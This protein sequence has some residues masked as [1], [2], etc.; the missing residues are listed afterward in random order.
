[1]KRWLLLSMLAHAGFFGFATLAA[2][3]LRPQFMFPVMS[4]R[5]VSVPPVAERRAPEP[6]EKKRE[7]EPRKETKKPEKAPPKSKIDPLEAKK[8][9]PPKAEVQPE[10]RPE[11]RAAPMVPQMPNAVP[12]PSVQ[13]AVRDPN[14]KF[15][16]YYMLLQRKLDQS[17]NPPPLQYGNPVIEVVILF[18]LDRRGSLNSQP[19]IE[20]SSGNAF[21]DQA[22]LRAVLRAAPFPPFPDGFHEESLIVHYKFQYTA[23]G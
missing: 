16:F 12:G 3:L 5:L 8:V 11:P 6:V 23:G 18:T 7:P 21:F 2:V 22:A 14:F 4:V 9:S 19:R 15:P 20:Q 10:P 17:W 13:V 1:M